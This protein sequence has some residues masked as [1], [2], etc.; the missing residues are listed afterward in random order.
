[1]TFS[2]DILG[3]QKQLVLGTRGSK[4]KLLGQVSGI[5]LDRLNQF[6]ILPNPIALLRLLA[7]QRCPQGIRSG[8]MP[9]QPPSAAS[10]LTPLYSEWCLV[11]LVPGNWC[12]LGISVLKRRY[13]WRESIEYIHVSAP[14]WSAQI[15][16]QFIKIIWAHRKPL[17]SKHKHVLE[18]EV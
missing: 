14:V 1:M 16:F 12:V 11:M 4:I 2:Q 13:Y 10:L 3:T 18:Y 7:G 5:W 6:G 9:A 8:Q 17:I 15:S